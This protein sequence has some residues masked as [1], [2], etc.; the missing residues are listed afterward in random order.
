MGLAYRFRE[1]VHYHYGGKHGSIQAGMAL[2]E[3]RVLPLALK[4]A[5]MRVLKP[6]F[7]ET[8]FLLQGYIS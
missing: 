5:R 4:E 1:S 6:T 3:L 7:T 2:E 8:H